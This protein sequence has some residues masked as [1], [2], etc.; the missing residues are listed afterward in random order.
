MRFW[1]MPGP[2][3]FLDEVL[4]ATQDGLNIVVAAPVDGAFGID[5]ALLDGLRTRWVERVSVLGSDLPV[6][7]VARALGAGP[8]IR[9]M[10]DLFADPRF[11]GLGVLYLEGISDAT[12]PAWRVFFSDY[13]D[14]SKDRAVDQRPLLIAMLCGMDLPAEVTESVTF[15]GFRWFGRMSEL[16]LTQY[17]LGRL[18]YP[19][20]NGGGRLLSASI[21]AKIALGDVQLAEELAARSL[22]DVWEPGNVLR[23]WAA[24]Q[25]WVKGTHRHW[26]RGTVFRIDGRDEMHSALQVLDDP[27]GIVR[28]RVWAAQAAMLLPAIERERL[29]LIKRARS[30]LKPPFHLADGESITDAEDLEIGPL[31]Y[32]LKRV[33]AP[34]ELRRRAG[35][36]KYLRNKLAHMEPLTVDESLYRG[37]L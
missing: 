13:D 10:D 29:K 2:A 5:A 24:R 18:E 28:S 1:S 14:L 6:A 37:L 26:T 15:R 3:G 8:M 36:L 34:E 25:G 31:E 30:Y 17:V 19:P 12:W 23:E 11:A 22:A 32:Q 7:Q 21:V 16:D 33:R 35:D 20:D 9:T 27:A 4:Q